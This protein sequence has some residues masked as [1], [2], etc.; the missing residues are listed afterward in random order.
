MKP[1][2]MVSEIMV[3]IESGKGSSIVKRYVIPVAILT[4]YQRGPNEHISLKFYLKF[5]IFHSIKYIQKWHL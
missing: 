4:Y 5:K 3:N 2:H 1:P